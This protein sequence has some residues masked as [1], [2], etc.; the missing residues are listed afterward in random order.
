MDKGVVSENSIVIADEE[1]IHIVNIKRGILSQLQF[2]YMN[3]I[4]TTEE[5]HQVK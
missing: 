4:E 3:N 5:V 2:P 1:P